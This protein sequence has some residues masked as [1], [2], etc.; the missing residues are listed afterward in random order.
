MDRFPEQPLDG[1]GVP[2]IAL[3]PQRAAAHRLDL[4]HDGFGGQLLADAG[5]ALHV[6]VGHHHIGA[7]P[8]QPQRIGA[9]DA[10]RGA[11]H[12]GGLAKQGFRHCILRQSRSSAWPLVTATTPRSAT[13]ARNRTAAPSR[14]SSTRS[15]SPGNT[16]ALKRQ[17]ISAI[18]AGS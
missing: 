7:Q 5:R 3:D 4:G 15:V 8:R 18:R 6:E 2:Q 13:S 10:A 11:G 1:P 9:P 17:P 16:G 14:H 12:D